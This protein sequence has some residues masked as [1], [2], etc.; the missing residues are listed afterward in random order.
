[1]SNSNVPEATNKAESGESFGSILSQ[2]ERSHT[3][4]SAEGLREGTVVSV[5]SDSVFV[6]LGFKTEGVLPLAEFSGDSDAAKV[7]DKLQVTIKGRDP[8]GYYL[9]TRSKAARPADW[10]ALERAFASKATIVGTVTGVVKG[11]LSVDV[12]V[13]AFMP[14]SRSGVRDAAE[15]EKLVEQEI[16]CRIIKLD[17][18]DE[19]VVV[20]RRVV[21]E[22]EERSAKDRRYSELKEDVTVNGTVRSLTDYGAFVDV[23][24]TD[25]LLHVSDISWGRIN[26]PADVLSVGQQ[27][28]VKV[29]KIDAEK[30]RISVG[31]KQLQPQPWDSVPG[32]YSVGERVRGTVTRVMDF[33]AFV[34]LEPGVEG[35][36]HVSEMSWVKKVRKPSDL[37]KPGETVDAV[38]LG[39]NPKEQR[40]ALGLKQAL[41]DPWSDIAQKF[42]VG[43]EVEGPVVSLTKFGAFVQL[44]EGIEGMVHVSDISAEKRIN[45]PQD[46]LRVGQTVK[47]V[48][49]E[50]DSAKRRL[51]LGMKQLVPTSIDE[52]LAEHKPAD[53]VSGR[54]VEVSGHTAQVELGEGIRAACRLSRAMKED[55]TGLAVSG[56]DVASLSSM[57]AARWKSGPVAESSKPQE[58]QAGQVRRFRIVKLDAGTKKIEVELV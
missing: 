31:M 35:L 24:G 40:M 54:V 22:E 10:A 46:V 6:D 14:A 1:M 23:G 45:H 7:G 52:Y 18:A 8:E 47:A 34:E 9:L 38:V 2:F 37:L 44:A 29:L 5:S 39:I 26:K 43:S 48:V 25:A 21:A 53:I 33:G 42:P 16:R 41:G 32:K 27:V 56:T 51:K 4:K 30:R 36:I 13:R 55:A 17:A 58:I 15:L 20:D 49:L 12:G 3:A 11:G 28:E 19:D 57:L 50:L